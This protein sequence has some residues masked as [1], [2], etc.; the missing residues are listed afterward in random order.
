MDCKNCKVDDYKQTL[1]EIF[2]YIEETCNCCQYF[3]YEGCI[4]CDVLQIKNIIHKVKE[5]N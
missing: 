5:N 4:K 3:Q 2:K 1:D